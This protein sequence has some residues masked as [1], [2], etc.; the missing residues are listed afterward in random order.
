MSEHDEQRALD[1]LDARGRS[2]ATSLRAALAQLD[3]EEPA[4]P[5]TPPTTP[6]LNNTRKLP[7]AA[8]RNV[9][10]AAAAIIVVVGLVAA[11]LALRKDPEDESGFVTGDPEPGAYLVPDQLPDGWTFQ[12]AELVD[13]AE[14]PDAMSAEIV[15]YGDAGADDPWAEPILMAVRGPNLADFAVSDEGE[16]ISVAGHEATIEDD[17]DGRLILAWTDDDG[18]TWMIDSQDIPRDAVITAGEHL[19]DGPAVEADGLP[20][21]YEEIARG[22]MGATIM[23]MVTG[24]DGLSLVYGSGNQD[25][26]FAIGT[27]GTEEVA[28][29]QRPGDADDAALLQVGVDEV[30]IVDV[31]GQTGYVS[32]GALQW[33]EQSTGMVVTIYSYGLE[34][35]ELQAIAESLRPAKAGEID[36]LLQGISGAPSG[37]FDVIQEGEIAVADGTHDDAEWTLVASEDEELWNLRLLT[38]GNFSGY[39]MY[40]DDEEGLLVDVTEADN[41]LGGDIALFGAVDPQVTEIVARLADGTELPLEIHDVGIEGWPTK[42][43]VGFVP[44]RQ[45]Y[46]LIARDAAGTVVSDEEWGEDG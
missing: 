1:L 5:L 32:A 3:L 12:R 25:A 44:S 30:G 26:G 4:G 20:D 16:S 13:L 22:P 34:T 29:V 2:A 6:S 38:P 8:P 24:L 31:R 7:F 46:R 28:V 17:G 43:V 18:I 42:A 27:I 9:W 14:E 19:A 11:F 41:T 36:G 39:G 15:V 37:G 33:F 23:A 35:D 21:G 45:V 10:L 40:K